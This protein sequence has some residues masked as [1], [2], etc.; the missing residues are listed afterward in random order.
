MHEPDWFP[1]AHERETFDSAGAIGV[2]VQPFMMANPKD[3]IVARFEGKYSV[4][5]EAAV[6]SREVR[7]V[8]MAQIGE[9]CIIVYLDDPIAFV[10]DPQVAFFQ[11]H[12]PHG[13]A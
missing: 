8:R 11:L 10:P 1:V 6:R 5:G 13:T 4:V 12:A 3:V 9:G 7:E 2:I